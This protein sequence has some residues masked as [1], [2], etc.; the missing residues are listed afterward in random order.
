MARKVILPEY[1]IRNII[2]VLA[3]AR[4]Y[5]GYIMHT[6]RVIEMKS[7]RLGPILLPSLEKYTH[8]Q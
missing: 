5:N 8:R 7:N 2:P 6:V 3:I 1:N 4:L